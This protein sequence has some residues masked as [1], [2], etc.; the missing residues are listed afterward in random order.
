MTDGLIAEWEKQKGVILAFPHEDTDWSD[1]LEEA[2][3]CVVSMAININHYETVYLL[4]KDEEEARSYFP[5]I[6]NIVYIVCNFN[7]TWMRDCNVLS[8]IH[9]AD[10]EYKG[11]EFTG[12]GGKFESDLD[13]RL[14]YVLADKNVYAKEDF[15]AVDY[16]LEG[17]AIE[18]D[19]QG[20]I[21]TTSS[22]LLNANRNEKYDKK[23]V[24]SVLK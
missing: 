11:F 20:T 1:C 2:R 19:G 12:W 14:K 21:L 23:S 24:E 7:D 10:I 9:N 4:C 3:E 15:Q 5:W 8:L 17:G 16:I 18:G 13:N 22:C 6:Q